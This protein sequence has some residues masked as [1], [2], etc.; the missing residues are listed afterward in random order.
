MSRRKGEKGPGQEEVDVLLKGAEVNTGAGVEVGTGKVKTEVK[1]EKVYTKEEKDLFEKTRAAAEI[2]VSRLKSKGKYQELNAENKEEGNKKFIEQTRK[3]WKEFAVHGIVFINKETGEPDLKEH[4]DLDGEMS[5][6]LLRLAGIEPKVEYVPQGEYRKNKINVDTGKRLGVVSQ[7]GEKRLYKT[8]WIDHHAPESKSNTS[9]TKITYEALVGL[10]LLKRKEFLDKTIEFVT[11]M[12]NKTFPNEEKYF[13]DSS[14]NMLGLYRFIDPGKLILFF[15]DKKKPADYLSDEDLKN[16][17]LEKASEEQNKAVKASLRRLGEMRQECLIIPSEKYGNIAV[18]IG[19][20]IPCGFDA[21]KFAGCGAYIIWSPERKSFFLSTVKHLPENF[22][23]SQGEQMRETMWIKSMR[24]RNDL[25]ITLEE[26]LSTMT[27]GKLEPRGALKKYLEKEKA[28][29]RISEENMPKETK[30]TQPLEKIKEVIRPI[31]EEEERPAMESLS[32]KYIT[33]AAIGEDLKK[34][35]DKSLEIDANALREQFALKWFEDNKD[36]VKKNGFPVDNINDA[37]KVA[38][39]LRHWKPEEEGGWGTGA[40]MRSE[41]YKEEFG[42]KAYKIAVLRNDM[43]K[44]NPPSETPFLL[45]NYL[46]ASTEAKGRELKELKQK[47]EQGDQAAAVLAVGKESELEKLFSIRKEIAEKTMHENLDEMAKKK[48]E[49][50]EEAN[51]LKERFFDEWTSNGRPRIEAQ[52]NNALLEKEWQRF[53][54][55]NDE[56]RKEYLKRIGYRGYGDKT[57]FIFFIGQ[58]AEKF[59]A[60]SDAFYGLLNQGHN[61]LE[62]KVQRKHW[63]SGEKIV[64]MPDQHGNPMSLEEYENN[65]QNASETYVNSINLETRQ[66]VEKVWEKRQNEQ[67]RKTIENRIKELAKSPEAA[68]GGIEEL[69]KKA[70]ERVITEYV[71]KQIKEKAPKTNVALEAIEKKFKDKGEPRNLTSFMSEVL[72]R[73]GSLKDLGNDFNANDKNIL[74]EFLTDW[75]MES[76]NSVLKGVKAEEYRAA[77]E[78]QMGFFDFIMKIMHETQPP[79]SKQKK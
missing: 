4:S 19:K 3:L 36:R 37:Y 59:E 41:K 39:V 47:A 6:E 23:L 32:E 43:A 64:I 61:P 56:Q 11:Q 18:D 8:A 63:W 38:F 77:R 70:R 5:L 58:S 9:A 35:I 40:D 31:E 73:R 44:K 74:K 55:F 72:F 54:L 57:S 48:V 1:P 62:I 53:S 52:K 67:V 13:L 15:K 76:P 22:Q 49:G 78:T 75:G 21:A 28:G 27:D 69:Y 42:D 16:Q 25:T 34:N 17:G 71:Q 45:L 2:T 12:D 51:R 60:G 20:K 26:I 30:E 50:G 33:G 24:D 79:A 68:E 7:Y 65:V 10:G 66:R 14:R 46:Q 29:G